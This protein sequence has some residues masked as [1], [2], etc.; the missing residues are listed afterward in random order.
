MNEVEGG[1]ATNGT[2][3]STG[4]YRAP[5]E[6]PPRAVQVKAV[7]RADETRSAQAQVTVVAAEVAKEEATPEAAATEEAIT[8]EATTE[9]AT[10]EE[11]TPE[12][13]SPTISLTQIYGPELV[14]DVCV[15]RVRAE[16]TGN[17][18]PTI[19]FNRDDSDG[20]WGNDVAQIN[21]RA[22]E[23]FT[24]EATATNSAGSDRARKEI[25]FLCEVPFA[26][27]SV[28]ASVSPPSWTGP[29]P[30]DFDFSAVITVNGPGTVT[31]R[32]ESS[33]GGIDPTRNITFARVGSQRVTAS[34]R[35]STSGSYWQRVR[36]LT[37][38]AIVSN[39]ANFTLTCEVPPDIDVRPLTV[40]FGDVACG[41]SRR[42]GVILQNVGT[43]SLN[44][45]SANIASGVV[46]FSIEDDECTGRNLATGQ[47]CI[48]GVRFGPLGVCGP[49]GSP[50]D[51]NLR[52]RSNDPYEGTVNIRLRARQG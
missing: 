25:N 20:A 5:F 17:P 50:Y 48:I 28:T 38:N 33:D 23:S 37:P 49:P 21:L 44:I 11:T 46:Y 39:R 24:L 29:C 27:T 13:T 15:Y 31:Y 34:F 30:T 43:G 9:E 1:D 7:A 35:W 26:V 51:G 6:V 36:V 19:E 8:E 40:D 2:I 3:S 32:W 14:G 52:I 10:T 16:V 45:S 47:E 18:R 12:A 41:S 42:W 22:G 4:L